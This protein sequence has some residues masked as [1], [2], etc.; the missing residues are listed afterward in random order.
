MS[1]LPGTDL[2]LTAVAT[3]GT[4]Q[5]PGPDST[6]VTSTGQGGRTVALT[7]D[8]GPDPCH[9]PRLLDLLARYRVPAVFCLQGDH[10]QD[11]PDLVRRIAEAGHTLCNHS[12]YHDDLGSWPAARIRHDLRQT[13]AAIRR[14]VPGADIRYFRAPYGNW[15]LSPQVA[16]ELGMQPLGWTFDIGDWDP[17]GTDEL[18]RR[19][20]DRIT[21]GAVALLHDGGG[22]RSRTVA[23]TRRT[24][25]LL[26]ARGWRYTLP[27]A[28]G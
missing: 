20:L 18:V 12:L 9:T 2:C 3:A 26:Q 7:F 19:I 8:D 21:P 24:I 13:S 27:A 1:L 28:H 6:V 25:P 10:A 11:R 4:A 16:V 15:G 14:A 17:P 22:D 5:T 23:A